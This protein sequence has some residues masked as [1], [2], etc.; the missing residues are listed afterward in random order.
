[1]KR[2][3]PRQYQRQVAITMTLYVAAMLLVWPIAKAAPGLWE[4]AALTLVPALPMLYVIGLMAWKIAAS[5]ELEQRTH[6]IALGAATAITASL[7]LVGGLLATSGAIRLDGTVLLWVFPVIMISYAITHG[8]VTR[9]YGGGFGCDEARGRGRSRSLLLAAALL[10][11]TA[12]VGWWRGRMDDFSLGTL[13]GMAA[14]FTVG[15]AWLA[16]RHRRRLQGED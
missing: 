3:S 5:D 12:L 6:L 10:G 9:R 4:K 1:M 14:T 15:S 2:L 7:G 11:L 8:L 13:I 16:W